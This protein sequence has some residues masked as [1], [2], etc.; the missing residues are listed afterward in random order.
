MSGRRAR[1]SYVALSGAQAVRSSILTRRRGRARQRARARRA[2]L[3]ADARLDGQR[4]LEPFAQR[5]A[6]S[7]RRGLAAVGERAQRT[8]LERPGRG[9]SRS[10]RRCAADGLHLLRA[11]VSQARA[12]DRGRCVARGCRQRCTS[13]AAARRA[14]LTAVR[15]VI[16]ASRAS[17]ELAA[18]QQPADARWCARR[19][20]G[21]A[22]RLATVERS[23]VSDVL[24]DRRSRVPSAEIRQGRRP[25]RASASSSIASISSIASQRCARRSTREQLGAAVG[26]PRSRPLDR[27]AQ[28]LEDLTSSSARDRGRH[29]RST[30]SATAWRACERRRRAAPRPRDD[31]AQARSRA[32]NSA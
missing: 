10:A 11:A 20:R 15:S 23:R 30:G 28:A 21:S 22:A 12:G 31:L 14:S 24:S 6:A 13:A 17:N 9:G 32:L 3:T 2:R 1:R 7:G 29:P 19:A 27:D 25:R 18:R 8:L 16:G 26:A 5:A 4:R